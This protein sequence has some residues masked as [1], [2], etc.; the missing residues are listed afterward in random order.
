MDCNEINSII[1]K[2]VKR[3]E[4][5]GYYEDKSDLSKGIKD[6]CKNH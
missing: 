2:F 4:R 1:E 5:Q 6:E 3:M